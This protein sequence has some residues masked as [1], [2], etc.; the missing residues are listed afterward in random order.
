M[1]HLAG[2]ESQSIEIGFWRFRVGCSECGLLLY[3]LG[4]N[5]SSSWNVAVGESGD[6]LPHFPGLV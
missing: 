3:L 2:L 5:A 1:G 4:C 6:G